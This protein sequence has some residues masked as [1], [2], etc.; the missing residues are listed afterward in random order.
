MLSGCAK[1][2]S[3]NIPNTVT[4]IGGFV[5]SDCPKLEYIIIPDCVTYIGESVFYN[6]GIKS[7]TISKNITAILIKIANF[8]HIFI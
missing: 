5:L 7:A 6:T 8:I 1:L 3:F 2:P 4:S